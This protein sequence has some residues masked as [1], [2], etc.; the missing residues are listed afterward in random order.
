MSGVGGYIHERV[1]L[2]RLDAA[3]RPVGAFTARQVCVDLQ[4]TT[5]H[6][7]LVAELRSGH[8]IAIEAELSPRRVMND[9]VKAAAI[10]ADELWIVTPSTP[11]AQAIHRHLLRR[12]VLPGA[13]GLFVLTLGQALQRV[14]RC[15]P[16]I[17]RALPSQKAVNND[18]HHP[19]ARC[20]P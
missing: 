15:F 14:T 11:N 13:T 1:I 4:G 8:C 20:R 5:C 2:D 9:L 18:H 16:L 7:D 6:I 12:S 17:P 19:P 3:F 10:D